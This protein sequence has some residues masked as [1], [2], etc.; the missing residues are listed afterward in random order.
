[1]MRPAAPASISPVAPLP[2][3]YSNLWTPTPQGTAAYVRALCAY[4]AV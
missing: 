3:S 4:S 2:L 1:M